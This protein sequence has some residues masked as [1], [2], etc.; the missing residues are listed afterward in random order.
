AWFKEKVLLVQAQAKAFQTDDLDAYDSDC[1]D[2]SSAKAVLIANLSSC[3]LDVLFEVFTYS[4][5]LR[6]TNLYT[7][8]IGDMMKFSPICLLSKVSKTKSWLWHRC[9]SYLNFDTINQLAK[10]GLVRGL[11]K[12][13]FEKDHLCSACSLRKSKKHSHKPK[14]EDTSQ[15]KLYLLHIDLCGPMRVESINGKKYIL[16]IVK[17]YSWFTW[18]KFLRSKDKAPE[19]IIKYYEDVGISYETSVAHTPQQ[20]DVVKR[21]NRSLVEATCTMLIYAKAPLFMWAEA[22]AIACKLKAKADVG[23]FIGYAPLTAM[24]S[25]QS[26]SGPALHKMTPGTLSLGF[27]PQPPS[28]KPFVP[29]TRNDRGTPSSTSVDQDAPS[30]STSQ[31]PQESPSHV[32]P[33]G[34][35]EADHDIEVVIP[36][37]VDSLNQPPE[38]ISKWTKGHAIGNVI[39]D[40]SRPV[41][42][43]HQLQTEAPF[44]YFNAFL[45][46]VELKSYKEALME[47]YW[48]EAI[49]EDLNEFEHPE[50]PNHVY[51]LKKVLYGLKQ[52]PHACDLVDT[53]MVDK[54]K[55]DADPQGKEVDP[56]RYRGM[57]GSLM[58]LTAS[59]INMGLWYSKD[60]CIAQTAFADA[61]H[62]GFQDT[63]RSTSGSMPLL[64][65]ELADILTKA[66]GQERLEV[67][68]NT[69]GMRS[70]SPDTLKSL[71]DE[72]EE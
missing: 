61:D 25:K 14:S 5:D 29:P 4:R 45:S 60:S 2:I 22:V 70:M 55:L 53:P 26:S 52:A 51:K 41:S 36:N 42:T 11:P 12:L 56:T 27:L 8:S 57:I 72:E 67:L 65:Y 44:Y 20:N 7:F 46:S 24:A 69:L 15:E 68:I 49:Q 48:I 28:S 71:A 9:L 66:L 43:R 21:R 35:E 64:E 50:N 18:V 47:S 1:D 59:T 37:N 19:F 38:H 32:I 39:G 16:V 23:I 40:P 62:A 34:A 10:Q 13:K 3:D 58:Y 54:S 6:G 31:T 33:P 30:P 17:D 63:K